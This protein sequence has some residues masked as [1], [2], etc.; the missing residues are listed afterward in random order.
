M[1]R[2]HCHDGCLD[3]LDLFIAIKPKYRVV[4]IIEMENLRRIQI[5]FNIY[6]VSF[7]IR[8]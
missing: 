8:K 5:L 1:D 7:K 6:H 2:H 3:R 4:H